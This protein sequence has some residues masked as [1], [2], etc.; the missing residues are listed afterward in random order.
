LLVSQ[1]ELVS[2]FL[3]NWNGKFSWIH[4]WHDDCA[5]ENLGL[6][7]GDVSLTMI[8]DTVAIPIDGFH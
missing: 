2:F 8:K 5:L 4:F 3:A 7:G 1:R 6:N